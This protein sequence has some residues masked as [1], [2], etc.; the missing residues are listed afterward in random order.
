MCSLRTTLSPHDLLRALKDIERRFGRDASSAIYGPRCLD[1]DLLMY[2]AHVGTFS[3]APQLELPHPRI[4]ER[5]FVCR[6]LHDVAPDAT[7]PSLGVS[8]ATLLERIGATRSP[9]V[10]PV[11]DSR[12]WDIDSGPT[13][14]MG[15]LNVTPDRS[16]RSAVYALATLCGPAHT[17][18]ATSAMIEH[19][20]TSET[21][22]LGHR[23]GHNRACY[24]QK[25]AATG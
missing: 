4:A 24:C 19:I 3:S 23:H 1:L 25:R 5:E 17:I 21:P 11:S 10:F 15:V 7:H 16:A 12:I 6:P 2:G 22:P 18:N 14:I 13:R 9:R 20:G 8:V